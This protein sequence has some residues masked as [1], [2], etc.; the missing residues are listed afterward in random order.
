LIFGR[1]H[2]WFTPLMIRFRFLH[3]VTAL[4]PTISLA[5]EITVEPRPFTIEKTFNATALP[6]GGCLL[7]Q[8]EPQAWADF[9]ITEITEHGGKVSKGD[10]LVRFDAE[11]IDKKLADTRRALET[12][13]L[14]LAQAELDLKNLLQTSPFKLDAYKRAAE[15]AKEE[16]TY[17]TKTRRN[18]TVESAEQDLVRRKQALENQQEELRQLTK[19]YAA[20]DVTEET[21]EIILTRQKDA[22]ASAEHML[23]MEQ[24]QHDRSIQV[25]LP[26]EAVSLANAERDSAIALAKAEQDI[27]RAIELKKLEVESL[28][29]SQQRNKEALAKLEKDRALFEFKAPAD[30][31]FYHGA[32]ENGRW[33]T[34]E[35]VRALVKHGKP[36]ANRNFATFVPATVKLELVAFLDDASART[37]KS[38]VEGTATLS[39]REDVEIPV[40]ITQLAATPG[41]DGLYRA[42]L[43]AEWPKDLTPPAGAVAQTRFIAYRQDK[44]ISIP[45]KALTRDAQGWTVEVKLADG[46]SDRRPVK[47]GRVSGE[48]TE[49]L[50]GIEAG[51]VIV[52]PDK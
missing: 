38:G 6:D 14:T 33:T 37:L 10:V 20:D 52:S 35:G 8:L 22:V 24:L 2:D 36:G 47:R 4:A 7:L 13:T 23:R 29:V 48:T 26:R 30:G 42:D 5:G 25:T 43:S 11:D 41:T 28:K 34:G 9:E 44:A 15:I 19:M 51:Q 32:I 40:K 49:I 21:E 18:A 39:G 17:F 3:L 31:W 50:S 46:K 16:N 1:D 27:P 45:S 12:E